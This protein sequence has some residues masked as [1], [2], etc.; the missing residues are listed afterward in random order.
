MYVSILDNGSGG[1]ITYEGDNTTQ[2][3]LKIDGS[4][5]GDATAL[6]GSRLYARANGAYDILTT[7]TI[8][9]YS[10]RALVSPPPLL[11]QYLGA[12]KVVR[13]VQ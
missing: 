12:Y 1:K 11:S 4:M 8:L 9:S 7:G 6:F 10:N 2:S 3:I 5:Y 13:V